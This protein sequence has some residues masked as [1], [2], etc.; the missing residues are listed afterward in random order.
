MQFKQ[1][2]STCIVLICGVILL[3]LAG[4]LT[5]GCSSYYPTRE[6]MMKSIT[7]RDKTPGKH[8]K[9]KIGIAL[10]ENRTH[11]T[12][13]K[14]IE[15]FT[16]F[17]VDN[18]T[19][20]CPKLLFIAPEESEM[21]KILERPP[22]LQSGR[23]D[24]SDL[25][26][27]GRA[28]GL[29]AIIAVALTSIS[30]TKEERGLP[31]F[32]DTYFFLRVE[33]FVEMFDTET[34]SMLL[35]KGISREIEVDQEDVRQVDKKGAIAYYLLEEALDEIA[36]EMTKKV[37]SMAGKQPWKGYVLAI[38]NDRV[39]ITSGIDV[40]LRQ[41]DRLLVFDSNQAIEGAGGH[42]FY[43]PGRHTGE[44]KITSV[45]QNTSEAQIVSGEVK[46]KG[47]LVMALQ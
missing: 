16:E 7:I 12:N 31:F 11:F 20:K 4:L 39:M 15:I 41:G 27:V 2:N 14:A 32:K 34:A 44:L 21:E 28:L 45:G 13:I 40:G 29:N 18:L 17:F 8:L 26:Q 43:I 19:E 6:Q 25:A 1:Q 36:Q 30:P 47:S 46:G 42:Q 33:A 10:F 24:N 22:R 5:Y 38:D 37:C 3:A 35:N 9:K 23:L